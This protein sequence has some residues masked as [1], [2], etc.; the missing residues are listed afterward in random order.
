MT[1]LVERYDASGHVITLAEN[2]MIKGTD[3]Q[4]FLGYTRKW[5]DSKVLIGCAMIHDLLRPCA[6]LCRALQN[7]DICTITAISSMVKA[8]KSIDELKTIDFAE[9]TH[10]KESTNQ[11]A[12]CGS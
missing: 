8:A 12:P 6:T 7:D 2:K 5:R 4:K 1:R 3:R 10:C 9:I 11:V